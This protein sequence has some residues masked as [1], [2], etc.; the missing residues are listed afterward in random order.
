MQEPA[1]QN[2]QPEPGE[3]HHE[4]AEAAGHVRV[5]KYP[6]VAADETLGEPR[7][8][9]DGRR[10]INRDRV[11]PDPDERLAPLSESA[12]I[13]QVVEQRKQQRGT[14][15][16]NQAE[17]R[18]PDAFDQRKPRAPG[19]AQGHERGARGEQPP[20]LAR[21]RHPLVLQQ[22]PREGA[23]QANRDRRQRAEDALVDIVERRLPAGHIVEEK[24][25]VVGQVVSLF[26]EPVDPALHC[27]CDG[28]RR[29]RAHLPRQSGRGFLVNF[30][31]RKRHKPQQ[32]PVA[33]K[34]DHGDG[35]H[36]LQPRPANAVDERGE[37]ITRGN[38]LQHAA[39]RDVG[40]RVV[41][42]ARIEDA[43][44]IEQQ[45]APGDAAGGRGRA[46]LREGLVEREDERNA[47]EKQEEWENQIV[48]TKSL[49]LHV[50][51]LGREHAREDIGVHPVQRVH[52][53]ARAH[54]P[55]HV[56][57]AQRVD[58]QHA[59]GT[60]L[61]GG[62]RFRGESWGRLEHEAAR[63]LAPGICGSTG[64]AGVPRGCML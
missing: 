63:G 26:K 13:D 42:A 28:E 36:H 46:L 7:K 6:D 14:A 15:A 25:D 5:Q 43:E 37:E 54:D 34:Q 31:I 61:P 32:C 39:E 10:E 16:G 48:E 21:R 35:G 45:A 11:H 60:G 27:A 22:A 40:P 58:R 51:Q 49:P 19:E 56:E 20:Y 47:D 30:E 2:R 55:E 53:R 62:G 50:A 41:Q 18:R 9:H 8:T 24:I 33:R 3:R 4:P 52:Q 23:E 57:T 29:L 12:H 38:P 44:E 59:I 64:K 1:E 17:R